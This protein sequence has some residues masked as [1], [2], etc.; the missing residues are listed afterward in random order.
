MSESRSPA[1]RVFLSHT[2]ALRRFPKDRSFVAAAESEVK[3]ARDAIVDMA[4]FE[5]SRH[6]PADFCR[7]LVRESDVYVLIAGFRLGSSVPERPEM[8][9]TELEFE[10]VVRPVSPA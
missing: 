7:K 6:L 5:A 10:T 9:Y 2:S 3:R 8:S 1:R 4:Y